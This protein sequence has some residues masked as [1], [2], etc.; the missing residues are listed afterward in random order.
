M[1]DVT[2]K[3]FFS[4]LNFKFSMKRAPH[5]NFFLQSVTIP[6]LSLQPVDTP[7]PF[8]TLPFAGEHL[9]Y[10]ELSITFRV[11]ED[12]QNYMEI[13]DWVRSQGKLSYEEYK[14]IASVP[15]I[16]GAG[17][18]SDVAVTVLTSNKRANYEFVFK[19]AFPTG[20]SSLD[21]DST[22]EDVNYVQAS[23][24]FRYVSFDIKKIV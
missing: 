11:D 7:T 16:T 21:L 22:T 5:V 8:V 15:R 14:A 19:D 20:I 24:S 13:H 18:K 12:L 10:G 1:V 6:S 3:N 2:N 17:L 23:A 4:P 9:D